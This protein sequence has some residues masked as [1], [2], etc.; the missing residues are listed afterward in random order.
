MAGGCRSRGDTG[1]RARVE[2]YAAEAATV[3]LGPP[4]V[5]R[6]RLCSGHGRRVKNAV[7]DTSERPVPGPR[8][9]LPPPSRR[10]ARRSVERAVSPACRFSARATS[11]S[12]LF[13]RAA[14]TTVGV[15]DAHPGGRSTSA[16]GSGEPR[17][18]LVDPAT[19]GSRRTWQRSSWRLTARHLAAGSVKTCPAARYRPRQPIA[20]KARRRSRSIGERR[21]RDR[22][23]RP[24]AARRSPSFWT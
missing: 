20:R 23:S 2:A 3:R 15:E 12:C 17:L 19:C 9:A 11:T 5:V 6:P 21:T 13:E 16:S 4:Q 8:S 24:P 10:A 14:S 7:S 22:S 1:A 18:D